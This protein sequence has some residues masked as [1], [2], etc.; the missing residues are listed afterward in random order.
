MAEEESQRRNLVSPLPEALLIGALTGLAYWLAFAYEAA[1]LRFFGL[2]THLV[3]VNLQTTFAVALALSGA[4]W[5]VFTV[6]NLVAMYWPLHPALQEKVTRAVVMLLFPLWHLLSYGFRPR[7]LVLYAFVLAWIVL[8]ELTWPL[9]V[10]RKKGPIRERL[11]AH[12][13]AEEPFRERLIASRILVALGPGA[14]SLLMAFVLGGLLA[15]T[16]G[17]GNA[18]T[19]REYF[20]LTDMPDVV[21][22]RMYHDRIL[23]A[24]FDR[25]TKTV[26]PQLIIRKA[27]NVRLSR[28]PNLGP[29]SCSCA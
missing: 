23:A 26:L 27:G 2:P 13:V 3:E 1:Y 25:K 4:S 10:F 15:T 22:L 8:V 20:V 19:Q 18:A 14:Y 7:D 24:P 12:E 5:V 6:V 21:V 17:R 29:L 16:A 11:I 9:L 28:E